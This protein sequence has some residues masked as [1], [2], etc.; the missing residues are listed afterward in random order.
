MAFTGCQD[1]DSS[2]PAS[3]ESSSTG[4]ASGPGSSSGAMGSSDETGGEPSP[5]DGEPL[6]IVRDGT[7][8]WFDIDGMQC[9]DGRPSGV[10]VRAVEDSAGLVLYFKGGGAC[11]N[12]STCGLSAPLMLTG[13]EAIE[14]NPHG[15]LDF[16]AADNPL[17]GYDVVYFPYCT[18]DVRGS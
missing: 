17:A 2:P 4:S 8:H 14:E 15:V 7:W 9:A 1:D 12:A 13:F 11:F 3:G 10:G 18:G 6:S 5:Y 16:E